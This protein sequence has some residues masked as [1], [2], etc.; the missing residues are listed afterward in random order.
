[1]SHAP[2]Y[3][4]TRRRVRLVYGCNTAAILSPRGRFLLPVHYY[5]VFFYPQ[6]SDPGWDFQLKP[7]HGAGSQE[8]A[9]PVPDSRNPESF[10]TLQTNDPNCP[11]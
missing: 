3:T 8:N 9:M 6:G 2:D 1:M 7:T 10:T 4:Y 11:S 5:L